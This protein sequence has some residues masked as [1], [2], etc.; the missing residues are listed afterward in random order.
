MSYAEFQVFGVSA[1]N[2]QFSSR[3]FGATLPS[4][5]SHPL[6]INIYHLGWTCAALPSG[7]ENGRS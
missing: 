1:E 2:L 5:S 7:N 3:K 4:G 6:I